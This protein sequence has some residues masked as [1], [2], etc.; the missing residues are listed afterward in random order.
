MGG[1]G[2]LQQRVERPAG[3]QVLPVGG[4]L[5]RENPLSWEFSLT[6]ARAD[7]IIVRLCAQKG[8]QEGGTK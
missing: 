6:P 3:A 4:M 1:F 2:V 8:A 7:H 5:M